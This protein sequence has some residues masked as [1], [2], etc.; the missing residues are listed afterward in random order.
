MFI[1]VMSPRHFVTFAWLVSTVAL[2][3]PVQAR[4]AS[5]P[6]SLDFVQR[7]KLKATDAA[8]TDLLGWSV[9]VSGEVSV[10]G[11]PWDDDGGTESGSAYVFREIAGVWQQVAKLVASDAAP[12][13][14]FGASAALHGHTAIIGAYTSDVGGSDRGA[15]YV[16]REIAGVWQQVAKLT[17]ADG[18]DGDFFG[19]SVAVDGATAIIGARWDDDHGANSGSAYIFREI[20][21]SW[22]QV[23][24]LTAADA[25]SDD[26]FGISVAISGNT[27]LVGASWGDDACPSVPDCNSGSAY[28]FREIDGTWQQIA[29]LGAADAAHGDL[30]GVSSAL[31]GDTAVI[32]ASTD[33]DGGQSSGSAY[34]FRESEGLWQQVAKLTASDAA[35][36]D[37][38][39][40]SVSVSDD[41]IVVGAYGD[42][43]GGNSSGSAYLFKKVGARW[44]Q[45]AKLTATDAAAED[46]FSYSVSVSGDT[47]AVGAYL[48]DESAANAGAAYIFDIS[49][50]SV[51]CNHND[52]PDA[53]EAEVC[54]LCL[55][56]LNCDGAVNGA[57]LALLLGMWGSCDDCL[58]DINAD[59][60]VDGADLAIL[61]GSWTG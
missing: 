46:R 7:A 26:R 16:F 9:A 56:D 47:V 12:G 55:G 29:K 30:F 43:D 19:W 1:S 52:V 42:D 22:Q 41:M 48:N 10:V 37:F 54:D 44:Q 39:G 38:F 17:A 18:E 24:K 45:L 20:G 32:G 60:I 28:V 51:D 61:L 36:F 5:D 49:L 23:A 3:T 40:A 2:T 25:E 35:P 34:V 59:G 13:D 53:C 6:C 11:A 14:Q 4:I 33:D 57:D 27:V 58:F 21:G 50:G 15:A 8:S 31:S